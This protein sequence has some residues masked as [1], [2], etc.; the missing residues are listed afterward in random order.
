MYQCLWNRFVLL[1][2]FLMRLDVWF[3]D[4]LMFVS[5]FWFLYKMWVHQMCVVFSDRHTSK[6][7]TPLYDVTAQLISHTKFHR[8]H[9]LSCHFH[10]FLQDDWVQSLIDAIRKNK[11]LMGMTVCFRFINTLRFFL[12]VPKDICLGHT[13]NVKCS[14]PVTKAKSLLSI[15][16]WNVIYRVPYFNCFDVIRISFFFPIFSPLQ[17]YKTGVDFSKAK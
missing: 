5:E 15:E 7:G 8:I 9:T 13:Y 1:F 3:F 6:P 2:F 16:H 10:K 17:H 12:M 4:T 11:A 14:I